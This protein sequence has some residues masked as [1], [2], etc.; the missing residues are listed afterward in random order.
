M[1]LGGCA[2][3]R[4]EL[5]P[6]GNS[7]FAQRPE[8]REYI[9]QLVRKDGFDKA[10]LQRQFDRVKLQP[11][12]IAAIKRP[13]ESLPWYKYRRI[14]LTPAR[15]RGGVAFWHKYRSALERAQKVYGV[16]PQMVTAII[17]VETYYGRHMGRWPVFDSL[18]TL[19]F[20]YPPRARFFQSQ[21]TQFLLLARQEK[22]DPFAVKGS[23]A[24]AMGM[25]QF[26]P[27]SYRAY[28]VDFDDNGQR[29]LWNDP[30]DAIG[31]VANYLA[32]HGWQAGA[33]VAVPASVKGDPYAT[34]RPAARPA[35]T[36]AQLRAQGIRP[37]ARLA[38]G[39]PYSVIRLDAAGGPEY[40]VGAK[41]FYVIMRYNYSPLY[42]MAVYQLSQDIKRAYHQGASG[43]AQ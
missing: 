11:A 41:N 43:D 36:L 10:E 15:V 23:Y 9:D 12:V 5:K 42:A 40:W 27:G 24:G 21:L 34:R 39:G 32:V 2:T 38:G 26:M 1:L 6:T 16:P 22:I 35:L 29:D 31:S 37:Q 20:D 25:G 33:G 17:G 4:A 30:I 13:A 28:A 18:A 8:V 3:S 14:F 19:G 7:A